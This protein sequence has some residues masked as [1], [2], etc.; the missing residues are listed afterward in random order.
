MC[1]ISVVPGGFEDRIADAVVHG[2][3]AGGGGV[4][5]VHD[6]EGRG[7]QGEDG[8]AVVLGMGGEVDEDVDAV[9]ADEVG[10][11]LVGHAVDVA[12]GRGVGLE[13]G[14]HGVGGGG[15]V[16]AGDVKGVLVVGGED[17]LEEEGDGVGAQ[18]GREIADAQGPLGSAVIVPGAWARRIAWHEE[19]GPAGMFR[20]DVLGG[21]RIGIMEEGE[22][23]APGGEAVGLQFDG[24]AVGGDSVLGAAAGHEGDAA[25]VLIL[26]RGGWR[27]ARRSR[28]VRAAAQRPAAAWRAA[29]LLRA[30][31]CSGASWRT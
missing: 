20:D 26:A 30:M 12:P 3:Q 14:G 24:A 31:G 13:A 16:V 4:G 29:R 9:G 22:Q 23:I 10:E 21:D 1:S 17:G 25:V 11:G 28:R 27:G 18:I 7:F 8:E 15:I 19:G 5:D 2:G 6:L